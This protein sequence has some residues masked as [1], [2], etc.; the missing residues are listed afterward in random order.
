M[1]QRALHLLL[2]LPFAIGVAAQSN[3]YN[4]YGFIYADAMLST[5]N[6]AMTVQALI[7]T[8]CS[9]CMID[10]TYAVDS[11]KIQLGATEKLILSADNERVRTKPVT[12]D[13]ISF[14]GKTYR[15]VACLVF[16]IAEKMQQY[17]PQF[18]IGANILKQDLWLF[19]LKDMLVQRNPTGKCA[20]D[21]TLKWKNH[22]H[23]AD[24]GRDLITLHAEINGIRGRFVFDTGSRN[25]YVPNNIKLEPTREVERET[26]S[27][28]RK[29]SKQMVK[30]CEN[31]AVTLGKQHFVL[32]FRLFDRSVGTLN[33]SFLKGRLFLLN[34][35]KRA[36]TV[37]R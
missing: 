5:P 32:D 13:S 8:G 33:L 37:L 15:N 16:N 31:V 28:S 20:P 17:T 23:Y 6:K 9:L 11:C 18:I 14:C 12:L 10:S 7:D 2:L 4:R 34:Y 22:R 27:A 3:L 21:Y 26:A 1:K 30:E 19:N 29:L 25:N 24:V 35:N 36:I